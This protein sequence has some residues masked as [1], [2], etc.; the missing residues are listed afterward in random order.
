MFM[1]RKGM[2]KKRKEKR[3]RKGSFKKEKFVSN[4]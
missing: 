1:I 2:I 4:K 3:T